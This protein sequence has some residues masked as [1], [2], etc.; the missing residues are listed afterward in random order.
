MRKWLSRLFGIVGLSLSL[1]AWDLGSSGPAVAEEKTIRLALQPAPL[2]GF[3]VRDKQLLEKRGYKTEW[4]VF[5]FTPPI[6]EAMAGG[7][8]DIALLGVGPVLSTAMRNPGI[9]YFYDELANAAGMVV[10]ADS[11]IKGPLDLKGKK[12]A[13]PGKASQ[14]YAQL[15][16]YLG[17]SGVK[18]T[19]IDLVRANATDMTTLFQ[20]KEVV[21]MLCWPPFTSE[22][23]RT[24]KAISLYTADDLLKRKA[25]HWLNAG[26]GVRA[27]Y[28]KQNPDAVIAVVEA[29][30][31]ATDALR[32]NPEEVYQIFAKATGYSLEAVRFLIEKKYDVYFDPK[33]SAPN[34][35]NMTYIFQVFEKY[36]IIKADKPIGPV[37]QALVHPE[38]VEQVLAKAK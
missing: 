29:L 34:V 3:Y 1:L 27:D 2:L 18:D 32:K 36:G 5:P 11:G 17:D 30:H 33:D 38:F 23:V 14:L 21:G 20:Q 8:V 26:W 28:A 13:F 4:N 35:A 10:R 22:L 6:L 24:G 12:I 15:L 19:D 16:M 37:M 7:S 9:W 31:E 25:G